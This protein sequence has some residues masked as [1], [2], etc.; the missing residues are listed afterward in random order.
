LASVI[1]PRL[2]IG[3][4]AAQELLNRINGIPQQSR[5]INLGYDIHLGETM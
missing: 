1:T 2:E 3:K 4:I 5:I